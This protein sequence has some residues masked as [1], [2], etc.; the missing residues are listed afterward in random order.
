MVD[1]KKAIEVEQFYI[2]CRMKG[3]YPFHL[4]DKIKECG[5]NSLV[6]FQEAK[7]DYLFSQIDFP[8]VIQPMPEGVSEIFKMIQTNKAG[9]LFVDWNETYVVAGNQGME[10]LNKK[11][12]E[13]NN[14]T[15]FPLYTNGGTI[16]G[17]T[18]D[19][20]LGICIPN[21]IDIDPLYLLNKVKNILQKYTDY[22]VTVEG[23]DICLDGKKISGTASYPSGDII[24]TIMHFSFT[25]WS[26]LISSICRPNKVGKE[27][28]FVD[29]M[30]RE[31]FKQEVLE[32]LRIIP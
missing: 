20:S 11:Y 9:T 31:Q 13:E 29:F 18:G 1:V 21:N 4:V 2:E 27:V 16:V 3:E 7:R 17:S 19:F 8:Q 14:I 10:T 32:W 26:D 12:C 15:I 30:T 24:M 5:F 6:E 25:N 22:E 28:A 23:N